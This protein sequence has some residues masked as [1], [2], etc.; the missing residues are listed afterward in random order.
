MAGLVALSWSADPALIRDIDTTERL[1]C[2]T[3]A[4]RPVENV[5]TAED[6]RPEGAFAALLYN[7]VCACGGVTG[8]PNNVYGCRFIDVGAAVRATLGE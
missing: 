6:E 5:C 8:V 2:Q 4:P 3:A 7:T 1:I